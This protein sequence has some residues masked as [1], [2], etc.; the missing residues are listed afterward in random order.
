M[1]AIK[2]H[3]LFC[4]LI[5][6]SSIFLLHSGKHSTKMK[7]EK[8]NF[9]CT[10]LMVIHISLKIKFSKLKLNIFFLKIY[11]NFHIKEKIDRKEMMF[12]IRENTFERL[13]VHFNV[14]FF[15]GHFI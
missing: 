10:N 6:L 11:T 7:V 2:L 9:I 1:F 12:L 3:T 14:N 5:D 4:N 8:N 13:D 15:F